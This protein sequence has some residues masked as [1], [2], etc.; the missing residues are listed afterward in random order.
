MKTPVQIARE[1]HDRENGPR[2]FVN[3]LEAHLL[4]GIVFSTPTA[5]LMA[6]Y[7]RREW[8]QKLIVDPWWVDDGTEM[9]CLHVYLAAG[10]L[11]EF[12]T[13]PHIPV[14][15]VSFERESILRF[16]PYSTLQRLCPTPR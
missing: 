9:N 16:H 10:D 6:R 11:K 13:F 4:N 15:Y 14:K 7:V 3:D 1:L 5:F 8:P 2:S 12:F